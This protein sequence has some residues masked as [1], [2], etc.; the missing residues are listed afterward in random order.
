MDYVKTQLPDFYAHTYNFAHESF[1]ISDLASQAEHYAELIRTKA[2]QTEV[3]IWLSGGSQDIFRNMISYA[4]DS[5]TTTTDFIYHH[6]AL[7][8]KHFTITLDAILD[9]SDK[10]KVFSC[11]Y[12]YFILNQ[13]KPLN[14]MELVTGAGRT[15][16]DFNKIVLALNEFLGRLSHMKKYHGRFTY[17]PVLGTLKAEEGDVGDEKYYSDAIYP[18]G[19]STN[20]LLTVP[21]TPM[22]MKKIVDNVI[23]NYLQT[24]M[25]VFDRD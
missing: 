23:H 20:A 6:V 15:Q 22:G 19:P 11:G 21:G 7:A 10:V 5:N 17:V 14:A 4:V 12:D 13:L 9:A 18:S 25:P 24:Y 8:E 3:Q 1:A 16:T 2:H